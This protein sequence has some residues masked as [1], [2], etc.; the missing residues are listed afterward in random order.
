LKPFAIVIA[1]ASL[2]VFAAQPRAEASGD[3]QA[4]PR[5]GRPRTPPP[6]WKE[7]QSKTL[8]L[9][10]E[11]KHLEVLAIYEQWVVKHP[12]FVEGHLMLAGAHES[13]ARA[14]R[15]SRAPDAQAT[16]TK[17]LETAA[18]HIRRGLE[19]AGPD[20][21][22][23]IMRGLIDV[24]GV[25]G[26]DRPA[27]YERLVREGVTR[28]PAEP[29]AHRYLLVLLATK[30]EPID[31]AARAARAAIPKGPAARVHLAGALVESV[32]SFGRLTPAL[33][34]V[35]LPEASRLIDEALKLKPGDARALDV[36]ASIH[37]LQTNSSRLP[38][39]DDSALRGVMA[40]I[41]SAQ[42]SHAAV[43]GHGFYAPTLAALARPEP[44]GK[45]NYLGDLV[46]AKGATVLERFGYR[47]EMTAVP[48]PKSPASCNGV[49]AGGSAETFSIVA[50]PMEGFHGRAYRKDADGKLTDIK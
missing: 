38:P 11:G 14:M 50:R 3:G 12:D 5:A 22:F 45:P 4:A 13:V 28:Y 26:L 37:D 20:D 16:R 9:T 46:P 1:V 33:A 8:D 24:H 44:G 34:T 27:E 41:A 2:L 30:G 23:W 35:L 17:H 39:A 25:L 18:V 48:S 40:A 19:L 36:R 21:S 49:P 42:A 47:I 7:L 43:C 32:R 29:L 10:L 6:G 31:A 15:T